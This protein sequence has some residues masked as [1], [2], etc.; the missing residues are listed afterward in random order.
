MFRNRYFMVCALVLLGTCTS[1]SSGYPKDD[2][3]VD[4]YQVGSTCDT[5]VKTQ[6]PLLKN[7][8]LSESLKK[9]ASRINKASEKPVLDLTVELLNDPVPNIFSFPNRIYITTGLL[10]LLGSKDELAYLMSKEIVYLTDGV[11]LSFYS[12][13]KSKK[14]TI[15]GLIFSLWYVGNIA[16]FAVSPVTWAV[17]LAQTSTLI[18]SPILSGSIEKEAITVKEALK[19]ETVFDNQIAG[20]KRQASFARQQGKEE[21]YQRLNEDLS[22]L[23]AQREKYI[24]E[25]RRQNPRYAAVYFPEPAMPAEVPTAAGEYLLRYKVTDASVLIWLVKDASLVHMETVP[26]KR[27]VLREKVQR[28]LA[29]FQGVTSHAELAQ[30]DAKLSGE[31]YDL[32][33]KPV[34][35]KISEASHV[36]IVPDDILEVLPFESLILEM[37]A[38]FEMA[39]GNYGPFPK[40][41]RYLAERVRLSYYYSATAMRVIR[42]TH[43]DAPP[44]QSLFVMADP[45]SPTEGQALAQD[46]VQQ[47]LMTMAKEQEWKSLEAQFSP[48]PYARELADTLKQL[49]PDGRVLVGVDAK[50]GN[51]TDIENY[52]YVVFATHGIL[53]K[54]LPYLAEPALLLSAEGGAQGDIRPRGFLTMS[55]VMKMNLACDNASLTACSTGLGRRSSGEGVMSMGWAFQYAGAKSVLV[56]LWNVEEQ[57]TILLTGR[58]FEHLKAGKDKMTALA[59]ARMELRRMGYEHPFYWAPFILIGE[60]N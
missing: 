10:D 37:P 11:H 16:I 27:E 41:V 46:E 45:S 50:K 47:K 25:V 5:L 52:R 53:A 49:F 32:L 9:L 21:A 51:L 1:F 4:L 56:S 54:E 28:Y 30:Y 26:L 7:A 23:G 20:L 44:T 22:R 14:E 12:S 24:Q 39:Q 57:S 29:P 19:V 3:L 58:F 35:G 8:E 43:M 59:D 15:G 17:W 34:A 33:F 31:L 60:V 40:G 48:L 2:N 55:E 18:G 42:Q 36:V 6:Y 13:E 38:K